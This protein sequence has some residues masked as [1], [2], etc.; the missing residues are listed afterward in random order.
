MKAHGYTSPLAVPRLLKIVVNTGIGRVRDEKEMEIIEKYFSMIAGQKAHR[1]PAKKSIAS[2]KSRQGMI[3][4]YS[5]TLRGAR[6]YDFLSRLNAV[7]AIKL[8]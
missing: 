7:Q 4:G 1:R 2:F 3:I 8:G 6:M 5:A